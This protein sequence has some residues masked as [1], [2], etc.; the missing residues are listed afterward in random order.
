M[1]RVA[2]QAEGLRLI[3][4]GR[5]YAPGRQ[6]R[7]EQRTRVIA[8]TSGKGGVGKTQVSANL[9]VSLA[10]S[11]KK[12]LSWM[13]TSASPASTSPSGCGRARTS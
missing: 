7:A 8:V 1:M 6:G 2:D 3:Q 4:G 11:G 5:A 13:R 9:G 12:V 10:Q